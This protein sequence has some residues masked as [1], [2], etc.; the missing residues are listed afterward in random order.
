[1]DYTFGIADV[2]QFEAARKVWSS[3]YWRGD[4]YPR[5]T[6]SKGESWYVASIG[7]H[8]VWAAQVRAAEVFRA[9]FKTRL[10][11]GQVAM[12]GTVPEARG[13]GV[14]S[15]A[16]ADLN[17]AMHAS[18]FAVAALYPYREAFYAK[19]GYSRCGWRWQ[20]K[21][22]RDRMPSFR[23]DLPVIEI[24]PDD[25]ARLNP[26]Y[27]AMVGR[28]SGSCPRSPEDWK[29]RLGKKPEAI[30]A[31]MSGDVVEGYFWARPTDFWGSL[32]VGELGWSTER[33]YR[34]CLATMRG[35]TENQMSATWS[36]PPESPFLD[37][38]ADQGVEAT[39]SRGTM[40]RVLDVERAVSLIPGEG[41]PYVIDVADPLIPSNCGARVVTPGK[42]LRVAAP[43][44]AA[45]KIGIAEFTQLLL[46]SVTAAYLANL[47]RIES[48]LNEQN[49]AKHLVPSQ[50]C[51]MDFF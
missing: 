48:G 42:A 1:M 35:L 27:E 15:K 14:A 46:G 21:V 17:R 26:C 25:V 34:S 51:C 47:G 45:L 6:P 30:Y 7:D 20:I 33:G 9:P 2:S 50:V 31:A 38:Y 19:S 41:D 5:E 13:L 40:F 10:T 4:P 12:V 49:L 44:E 29:D 23:A 28:F 18:G 32:N 11:C 8:V 24:S 36:E 37:H 16:M 39:R 22:P 3:V 43:G